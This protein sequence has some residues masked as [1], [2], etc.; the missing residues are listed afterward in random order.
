MVEGP[1]DLARGCSLRRAPHPMGLARHRDAPTTV[2][3]TVRAFGH[4]VAGEHREATGLLRLLDGGLERR[5]DTRTGAPRDVEERGT[6]F[7]GPA[8][9]YPPRS[10]HPTTGKNRTPF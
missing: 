9:V 7:S 2:P 1:D 3:S 10:A 8:A 6:G 4:L 5:D